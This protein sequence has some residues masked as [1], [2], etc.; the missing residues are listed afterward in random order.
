[1]AEERL[2]DFEVLCAGKRYAAAIYLGVYAVECLLKAHVCRAL[3]L[4]ELPETYRSHHLL[5]LLLHSGL[6][7]RIQREPAVFENLKKLD[8]M[9]NPADEE[10][11]IRYIDDPVRYGETQASSVRV[12][13]L[14][15]KGGVITWLRSQL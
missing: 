11:N 10:R 4:D 12:W 2:K 9:W 15:P 3:D 14:N 5:T 13:M 6:N 7:R 1:L 8:G